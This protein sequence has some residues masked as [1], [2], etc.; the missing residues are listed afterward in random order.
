MRSRASARRVI[1]SRRPSV[2][3]TKHSTYPPEPKTCARCLSTPSRRSAGTGVFRTKRR[4][5]NSAG[6]AGALAAD[7]SV[8]TV[9]QR[10]P[11]LRYKR[12]RQHEGRELGHDIVFGSSRATRWRKD[13]AAARSA[14]DVVSVLAHVHRWRWPMCSWW[15]ASLDRTQTDCGNRK[16]VTSSSCPIKELCCGLLSYFQGIKRRREKRIPRMPRRRYRSSM[17]REVS[18]ALDWC[19]WAGMKSAPF[20]LKKRPRSRMLEWN[21]A[22]YRCPYM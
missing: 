9:A 19:R 13:R 7:E 5:S 17:L 20:F 11:R 8:Q 14:K 22:G 16:S 21:P 10:N 4:H 18:G 1:N 12:A 15:C 2:P 3:W 6:L